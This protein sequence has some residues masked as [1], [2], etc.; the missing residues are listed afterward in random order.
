MLDI[1]WSDEA[2]FD[3]DGQAN[4]QNMRFWGEEKPEPLI[5]KPI[6]REMVTLSCAVGSRRIMG[7]YFSGLMRA[8][9]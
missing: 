7:P 2:H 8:L 3:L 1:D 5:E 9:R 6:T 4:K